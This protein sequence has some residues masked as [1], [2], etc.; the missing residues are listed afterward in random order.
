MILKRARFVVRVI[1]N[2]IFGVVK[3]RIARLAPSKHCSQSIIVENLP[4]TMEGKRD[5]RGYKTRIGN[6]GA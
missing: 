2:F 4:E 6:R 1:L 5:G 3:T